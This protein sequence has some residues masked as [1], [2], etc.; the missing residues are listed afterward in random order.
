MQNADL[1]VEE[2]TTSNNNIPSDTIINNSLVRQG[3]P[4]VRTTPPRFPAKS[5]HSIVD[6]KT[7]NENHKRVLF[8]NL[9]YEK[10][11]LRTYL[12]TRKESELNFEDFGIINFVEVVKE[13]GLSFATF[14]S[15]F[16]GVDEREQTIGEQK[17]RHGKKKEKST[18]L[19][20]L[21]YE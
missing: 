14:E 12:L 7:L 8:E 6:I 2:N 4:L 13:E 5:P 19:F 1:F 3:P 15:L 18:R 10:Q 11:K 17:G 20:C 21:D 16:C 9:Q